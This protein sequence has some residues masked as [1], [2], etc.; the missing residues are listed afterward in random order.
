MTENEILEIQNKWNITSVKEQIEEIYNKDSEID[1]L[2]LLKSNSFLFYELVT[3]K[4][5][6]QPIFHEVPLGSN[7]RCDFTWLNDN[8]DGPEWVLLEIEKPKKKL[9]TKKGEPNSYL[10]HAIEQVKS[11]E[12]YFDENTHEKRK[13]FGA[14]AKFRY[15]LVAGSKEEWEEER[16]AKWRI[17]HNKNYKIEI[18]S[19]DILLRPLK[20]IEEHPEFFWSF[21]DNPKTKEP[22]KLHEYWEGYGYMDHWRKIL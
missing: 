20:I 19:S 7:F 1:L 21:A 2:L 18:H 5:S 14:V 12:R 17:H 15:I 11:W 10:N 4:Y 8:S 13:I 9:F 16:H 22:S 6:V 3:R